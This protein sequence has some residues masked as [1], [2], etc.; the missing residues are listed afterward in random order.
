MVGSTL[1]LAGLLWNDLKKG[2]FGSVLFIIWLTV[3][4]SGTI[5]Y[6][7]QHNGISLMAVPSYYLMATF[8]GRAFA[9]GKKDNNLI[10]LY[11]SIGA[12]SVIATN[13]W[14]MNNTNQVAFDYPTYEEEMYTLLWVVLFILIHWRRNVLVIGGLQKDKKSSENQLEVSNKVLSLIGHNIRTPLTNLSLQLQIAKRAEPN[15]ERYEQLNESVKKLIDITE[16][17]IVKNKPISESGASAIEMVQ[18]IQKIYA[19]DLII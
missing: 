5:V 17:T 2:T 6:A 14:M 7:L 4:T 11:C 9:P 8:V 12:I 18:Q 13:A 19:D 16:A 15:N 10:H 1:S 3:E